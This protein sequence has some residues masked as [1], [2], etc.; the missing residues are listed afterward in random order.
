[1]AAPRPLFL[2]S[3]SEFHLTADPICKLI[4]ASQPFWGNMVAASGAGPKPIPQKLLNTNDLADAILYCLSPEASN[5]AEGIARMM[6]T[7]SGVE[8]AV[9]SFYRNLP[10]DRMR[11]DFLTHEPAVW[12]YK[13]SLTKPLYLSKTAAQVLTGHLRID[14]KSLLMLVL[15]I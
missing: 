14:P 15:K 8:A 10:L 1:M 3:E 12:A 5:A 13:K 7:E 2:S 9:Q 11:C 6:Q 4:A